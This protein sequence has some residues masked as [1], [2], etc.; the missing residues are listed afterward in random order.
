M[1]FEDGGEIDSVGRRIEERVFPSF[2]VKK[3][4]HGIELTEVESENFHV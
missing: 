2:C 1:F 3:A 4:A